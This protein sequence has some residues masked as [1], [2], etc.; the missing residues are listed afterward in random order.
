[1]NTIRIHL[2]DSDRSCT[3]DAE[4]LQIWGK[5]LIDDVLFAAAKTGS[6]KPGSAPINAN[7]TFQVAVEDDGSILI[8]ND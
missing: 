6:G 8:S 4:E 3:V 5:Q 7:V 2:S 1:M